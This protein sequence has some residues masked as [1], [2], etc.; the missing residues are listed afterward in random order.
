MIV[1]KFLYC[2]NNKMLLCPLV[3]KYHLL[4]LLI[5]VR[6]SLVSSQQILLERHCCK[7]F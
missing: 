2:D 6:L 4:V 5:H 3:V 1:I 7:T